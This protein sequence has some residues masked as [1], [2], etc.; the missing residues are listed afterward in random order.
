MEELKRI[1]LA[2]ETENPFYLND[3]KLLDIYNNC[4]PPK[5]S[6]YYFPKGEDIMTVHPKKPIKSIRRVYYN[7]EFTDYEN[8]L[9]NDLKKIINSD[10]SLKLPD[11][12]LDYFILMF[13]G[14][15]CISKN[16]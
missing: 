6:Y 5:E 3:P 7:I 10:S 4:L 1:K 8:K 11:Y 14:F 9:L 15:K 2:K 12:F 16:D 13:G